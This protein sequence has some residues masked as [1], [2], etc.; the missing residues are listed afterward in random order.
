MCDAYANDPVSFYES[1]YTM[2]TT[3]SLSQIDKLLQLCHSHTVDLADRNLDSDLSKFH[4][5]YILQSMMR[6]SSRMRSCLPNL[7]V[8]AH[9]LLQ[10]YGTSPYFIDPPLGVSSNADTFRFQDAAYDQRLTLRISQP[11]PEILRS[12][13]SYALNT[14]YDD[15]SSCDFKGCDHDHF[16]SL[17][18]VPLAPE[19]L[20][21]QPR[22]NLKNDHYAAPA[23]DWHEELEHHNYLREWYP[24]PLPAKSQLNLSKKGVFTLVPVALTRQCPVA[25]LCECF[26]CEYCAQRVYNIA[27]VLH[28]CNTQCRDYAV[29]KNATAYALGEKQLINQHKSFQRAGL[30]LS[31]PASAATHA[32]LSK[33]LHLAVPDTNYPSNIGSPDQSVLSDA[34]FANHVNTIEHYNIVEQLRN[35]GPMS[36]HNMLSCDLHH[37]VNS[38]YTLA[39]LPHICLEELINQS[40]DLIHHSYS[41]MSTF[42]DNTFD[43]YNNIVNGRDTR[44]LVEQRKMMRRLLP[45]PND[46]EDKIQQHLIP[47]AASETASVLKEEAEPLG[48]QGFRHLLA[49]HGRLQHENHRR[50]YSIFSLPKPLPLHAVSA[51]LDEDKSV[52]GNCDGLIPS[53]P[54]DSELDEIPRNGSGD[55]PTRERRLQN[56]K[57]YTKR[58]Q[59]YGAQQAGTFPLINADS[60]GVG[61]RERHQ[62]HEALTVQSTPTVVAYSPI[63]HPLTAYHIEIPADEATLYYQAMMHKK[64]FSN[65]FS[66]RCVLLLSDQIDPAKRVPYDVFVQLDADA[67]F[68]YDVSRLAHEDAAKPYTIQ[69]II[70]SLRSTPSSFP[71][72]F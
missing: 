36:I 71:D 17:E 54:F 28:A 11:S 21:D 3:V 24:G 29:C 27:L 26:C 48:P 37:I 69:E 10:I 72:A 38:C 60:W 46:L 6:K 31:T 23:P 52:P 62:V 49:I 8:M 66:P 39:A 5:L 55:R 65:D 68:Q 59:F 63:E 40:T 33:I 1:L 35:E 32:T 19:K 67:R 53:F 70:Q 43:L 2:D 61:Q 12:I 58:E 4:R 22:P 20:H 13:T 47:T 42:G 34:S 18:D 50:Y 16:G 51:P 15:L 7:Y 45:L 14:T 64:Q 9:T 44:P 41:A 30:A 57:F 56:I 25:W